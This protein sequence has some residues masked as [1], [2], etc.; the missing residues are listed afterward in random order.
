MA[1]EAGK[2]YEL[3]NGDGL[4]VQLELLCHGSD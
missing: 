3:R 2:A 4:E 1:V